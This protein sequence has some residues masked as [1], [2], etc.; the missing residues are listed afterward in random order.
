[1]SYSCCPEIC[2]YMCALSFISSG[3]SAQWTWAIQKS[4]VLWI[5]SI[6]VQCACYG[7]VYTDHSWC[8][9]YLCFVVCSA[10]FVVVLWSTGLCDMVGG[11]WGGN[12]EWAES[13]INSARETRKDNDNSE[14]YVTLWSVY[15]PN[16]RLGGPTVYPLTGP[17]VS[18]GIISSRMPCEVLW[19]E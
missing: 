7:G 13:Y 11:A 17:R 9:C 1:M 16:R 14:R 18:H 8:M 6:A 15:V 12:A 19:W 10:D 4:Q 5:C 3:T 2:N